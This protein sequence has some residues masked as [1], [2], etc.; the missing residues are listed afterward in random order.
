MHQGEVEMSA[1]SADPAPKANP[2]DEVLADRSPGPPE[3]LRRRARILRVVNVPMRLLLRLPFRTPLNAKLMLLSFKGRKTGR[4]YLQPVSYVRDGDTLLTPAGG[5]WKLNLS[6]G[7]PI[8]VWLRGV[9]TWA[10]PAFVR[11][12][13]EVARLLRLMMTR[14]PVSPRLCLSSI[15]TV[16]STEANWRRR[17][18]TGSPSSGGGWTGT[19]DDDHRWP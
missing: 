9:K 13:D 19:R 3:N 18:R 14:N 2:K 15:L 7:E 16:T 12:P 6:E 1:D 10:S 17:S 8:R 11:D 5:K 4:A